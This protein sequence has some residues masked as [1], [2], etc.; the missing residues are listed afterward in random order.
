MLQ[1]LH[2]PDVESAFSTRHVADEI[3][4]KPIGRD[5]R[6]GIAG[7]GILG[8]DQGCGLAPCRIR[9]LGGGYGGKS[10][11]GGISGADGEIHRLAIW[12]ET[13]GSLIVGRIQFGF[14]QFRPVPLAV[15]IFGSHHD[16]G[17]L[18]AG[19]ATVFVALHLI[20]GGGEEELV[21]VIASQ[22]GRIVGPS[23]V[24]E[25][26]LLHRILRALRLPLR[27]HLCRLQSVDCQLVVGSTV[28]SH[29][30]VLGRLLVVARLHQLLSETQIGG[31]VGLLVSHGV[32]VGGNGL[33]GIIDSAI[34]VG[35]FE[36]PLATVLPILGWCR[37]VGF[38]VLRSGIVV[39]AQGIELVALFHG[40][41][42]STGSHHEGGSE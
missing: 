23:G 29:L 38:L 37:R 10:G 21:V 11:R 3:E 32:V 30:E 9:A 39:F 8:D 12:R 35:Q 18:G 4:P 40:G 13:A 26:F 33:L 17:I 42:G 36:C 1:Q 5:G 25:V 20:A 6:M 15:L 24:E 16:V 19:D 14:Y 34:A 22:H 7:E 2:T 27:C 31:T 41:V 28:D